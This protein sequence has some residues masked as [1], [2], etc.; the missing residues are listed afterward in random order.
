[1]D[2][3]DVPLRVVR[4]EHGLRQPRGRGGRG[5][6]PSPGHAHPVQPGDAFRQQPRRGRP[7][8]AR[9]PTRLADR[10][11]RWA[12]TGA[13]GQLGR[14]LVARLGPRVAWA[15]GREELDVSDAASVAR[16]LEAV[17][18]DVVVNAAAFNDVD[19]AE[20]DPGPAMAVN[21]VGPGHLARECRRRG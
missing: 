13:A 3:Q 11:M 5:P 19:G 4:R 14:A 1:A 2:P 20:A 17:R 6:G 10:R 18:P 16:V 15:G 8:R 12:V 7:H 21:A 9:L